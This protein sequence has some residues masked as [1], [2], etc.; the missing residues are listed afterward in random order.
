MQ[1]FGHKWIDSIQFYNIE[2][3]DDIA[4]T[5]PNSI[6][7]ISNLSKF[8]DIVK[9]CQKN[10]IPFVLEIDSIKDAIFANI[11]GAKYTIS[12]KELAKKIMPIAQ[13]Y[14]FDTQIL[15]KISEDNEIEEMAKIGVDGVIFEK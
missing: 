10:L 4:S 8:I 7:K 15:A 13:N 14:L 11:F 2:S 9:H 3:I 6:V 12:S 1:I 5:P